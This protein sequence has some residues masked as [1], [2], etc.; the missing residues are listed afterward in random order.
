VKIQALD[1][2][3]ACAK[4]GRTLAA[5]EADP[6]Q[7]IPIALLLCPASPSE[8]NGLKISQNLVLGGDWW[9]SLELG[10]G[11]SCAERLRFSC[12][13]VFECLNI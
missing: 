12:E 7:R 6:S 8:T 2:N 9:T 11:D 4:I 3:I 10:Q 1:L 5:Y 13:S